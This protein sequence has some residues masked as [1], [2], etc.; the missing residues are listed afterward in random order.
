MAGAVDVAEYMLPS[1][2]GITDLDWPLAQYKGEIAFTDQQL[3][4]L[5]QALRDQG[6]AED[7]V[8]VVVADHGESLAEHDYYFNH[9]AHLYTPSMHVP[10][11]IV[12]PGRI[13]AGV[14]VDQLVENV[15]LAPTML[16]LLGQPVPEDL[17]GTSLLPL[18]DGRATSDG[19][20]LSITF[21]REANKSTGAFMRYR[22][23]GIRTD[24]YSFI[25]R[26][27]GPEEWYA[28]ADDPGE[29][30][31]L[32]RLAT[33][34]FLVQDHEARSEQILHASG[35][36]AHERGTLG[37]GARE[38]LEN[39]GYIDKDDDPSGGSH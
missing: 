33:H 30:H 39:L 21:D 23:I 16:Q 4:R 25:F 11:V 26:E 27:E 20:S 36:G 8:I 37:A 32:S 14:R 28:L 15:D 29:L 12:A 18:I 22:K 38:R 24:S 6:L 5:L 2:E 7:T 3:G 1:L 9:G 35:S 13:P 10:M 34:A 19:E 17:A 31:D